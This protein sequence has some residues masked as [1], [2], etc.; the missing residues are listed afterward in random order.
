[1]TTAKN[2]EVKLNKTQLETFNSLVRLGDTKELALKTVLAIK[3]TDNSMY[4]S[5]YTN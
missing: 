4:Q 3:Q 2:T 1:M 5:A